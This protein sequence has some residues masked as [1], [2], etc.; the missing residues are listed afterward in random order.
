M[1]GASI[2]YAH[3]IASDTE[4]FFSLISPTV[5]LPILPTS[6]RSKARS[7]IVNLNRVSS[8]SEH[9]LAAERRLSTSTNALQELAR[10]QT[11]ALGQV[12]EELVDVAVEALDL[13]AVGGQEGEDGHGA[14]GA[15]VHVPLLAGDGG[16][17]DGH[18]VALGVVVAVFE[19]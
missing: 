6:Q 2:S 17:A 14:V 7:S 11:L 5:A 18:S 12:R 10:R 4:L 15:L 16:A 9:S 19:G 8:S 13:L 3:S 1:I